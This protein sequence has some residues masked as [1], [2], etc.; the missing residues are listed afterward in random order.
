MGNAEDINSGY[1]VCFDLYLSAGDEYRIDYY[2][3]DSQD[4][5]AHGQGNLFWIDYTEDDYWEHSETGEFQN[6]YLFNGT[7]ERLNWQYVDGV[8][9][10][11]IED[12]AVIENGVIAHNTSKMDHFSEGEHVYVDG[13]VGKSWSDTGIYV[14]VGEVIGGWGD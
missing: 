1:C 7:M 11:Y 10:D 8:Y 2:K 14:Q 3:G 9:I 5:I 6:G 12:K 13:A 4:G